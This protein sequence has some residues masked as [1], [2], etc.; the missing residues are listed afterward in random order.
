MK[1]RKPGS[2]IKE[3]RRREEEDRYYFLVVQRC[4]QIKKNISIFFG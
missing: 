3:N 1:Q 4:D 2:I